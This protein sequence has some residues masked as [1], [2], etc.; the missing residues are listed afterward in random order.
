MRL[1][2]GHSRQGTMLETL[3]ATVLV[4]LLNGLSIGGTLVCGLLLYQH[5]KG[6]RSF[7]DVSL[8]SAIA[9]GFVVLRLVHRWLGFRKGAALLLVHLA[10]SSAYVLTASR[11]TPG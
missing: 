11:L 6:H 5:S 1:L 2:Q 7:F 4:R 8:L 9:L 3:R 10:I